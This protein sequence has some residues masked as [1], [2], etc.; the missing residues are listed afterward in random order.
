[1]NIVGH[2][3]KIFFAFNFLNCFY[4]IQKFILPKIIFILKFIFLD[5]HIFE[6]ELFFFNFFIFFFNWFFS[7]SFPDLLDSIEDFI[8]LLVGE[9]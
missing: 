1:L 6:P 7:V 3:K 5:I 2:W 9:L 8:V 4:L